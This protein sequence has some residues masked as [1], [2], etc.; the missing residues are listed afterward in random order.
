MPEH[1]K[2]L[3]LSPTF[4][5][6]Q[7]KKRQKYILLHFKVPITLT[8]LQF[9]LSKY[10]QEIFCKKKKN[11]KKRKEDNLTVFQSQ[12]IFSLSLT[13]ALLK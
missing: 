11:K 6:C 1:Q 10:L 2:V 4:S 12:C 13:I 9:N 7:K 5:N 3:M 8:W